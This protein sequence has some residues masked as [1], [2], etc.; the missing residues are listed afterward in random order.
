MRKKLPVLLSVTLVFA[1][2][3]S[4]VIAA[5][6]PGASCKK[7]GQISTSAGKKYTCVKSGSKLVWNKGVAIKAA[8]RP[9][10]N[11]VI[12]N[13][14]PAS[15]PNPSPLPTPAK[16]S[17][18]I[19]LSPE[20]LSVCR[21]PAPRVDPN[22]P[23]FAYPVDPKSIYAMLPRVG[24]IN[25][26]VIPIDFSDVN[27]DFVPLEYMDAQRTKIDSWMKWY[28]QGKSYYSWNVH[29]D[30]IRAPKPSYDYVPNDTAGPT[31][32]IP[33][34]GRVVG[35]QINQFEAASELLDLASKYIDYKKMNVV[36]FLFPKNTK[37]IYDPWVR[38]GNFQGKGNS[39]NGTYVDL[40]IRDT[41]LV[42]VN[43][44]STG[45]WFQDQT[46]AFWSWLLHENLH[47]QGLLG[48]A[49][50]GASPLGIMTNQGGVRLPLHA[51]HSITL[52]W[53]APTD[54]YCLRKED[55]KRS[56]I[57]MS[58]LERE[59]VGTKAI[60][61]KLSMYEVLVIESRRDDKWVNELVEFKGRSPQLNGLVVYKV[62]VSSVTPNGVMEPDGANWRDSSTSFAYLIRNSISD[63]GYA[64]FRGSMPFDLNFII[65]PGET[66]IYRGIKI[67]LI[68][69]DFHDT[70]LIDKA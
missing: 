50:N 19:N 49:P 20:D 59:E 30:W 13:P 45:Y 60:M 52:D 16:K 54:I 65:S 42:N 64:N 14:E 68:S 29:H 46:Q 31:Q 38:N 37:N 12:N 9:S 66:M 41:R 1:L 2:M 53:Q 22:I 39:R 47:N 27:G 48:H 70:V 15:T 55:I 34:N 57:I 67:S 18:P 8:P 40:G 28:S 61:I 62:D 44:I 21:I 35:R 23:F 69:S 3:Q 26:V 6:K 11:P 32:G 4:T 58:P 33:S 63:K 25:T 24:P 10:S 36:L 56:E 51:W 7:L 5:V 43:I 17:A